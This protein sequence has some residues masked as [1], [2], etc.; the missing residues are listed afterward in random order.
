M[1]V[2]IQIT[3]LLTPEKP[4]N[5]WEKAKTRVGVVAGVNFA[6][7]VHCANSI[8]A[9]RGAADAGKVEDKKHI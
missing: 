3:S 2:S 7:Y 1:H 5:L 6:L 4:G 8:E 9:L